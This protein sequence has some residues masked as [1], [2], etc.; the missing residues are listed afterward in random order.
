[1][2][3][4]YL[5]LI[6]TGAKKLLE[7]AADN[8]RANLLFDNKVLSNGL[9]ALTRLHELCVNEKSDQI[10]GWLSITGK[11][12]KTSFIQLTAAFL[13]AIWTNDSQETRGKMTDYDH[14]VL[15]AAAETL[16]E[17]MWQDKNKADI[18]GPGFIECI[19]EYGFQELNVVLQIFIKNYIGNILQYL[20]VAGKVRAANPSLPPGIEVELKEKDAVAISSY[21][22]SDLI[23]D[24]NAESDTKKIVDKL[25]HTLYLILT[26]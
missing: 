3:E 22:F 18:P 13:K 2:S 6:D 1:M 17:I 12:E 9:Q 26:Q 19:E 7:I 11:V 5:K 20:F 8:D 21:I 4:H 15:M 16:S 23:L 25:K 14:F 10:I 24:E